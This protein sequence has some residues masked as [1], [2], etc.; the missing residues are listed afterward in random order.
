MKINHSHKTIR[1]KTIR[2]LDQKFS[3]LF[4]FSFLKMIVRTVN[5]KINF[6]H[7]HLITKNKTS[8]L[9]YDMKNCLKI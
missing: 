9:S 4:L 2:I 1:L 5:Q 6:F 3:S 8:L 7:Y